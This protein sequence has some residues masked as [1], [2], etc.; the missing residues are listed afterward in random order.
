MDYYDL[1]ETT[2]AKFI[3][4]LN[5]FA[6]T[7]EL[8]GNL[9]EVHVANT[10]RMGELLYNGARVWLKKTDNLKRKL[11]Y[12]LLLSEY[13]GRKICLNA[14]LA[15]DFLARWLDMGY[16]DEFREYLHYRREY[17]FRESR[18]DFLLEN[19]NAQ[20]LLLEVKSVNYLLGDKAIFP[21]A[22]TERGRR[23]LEELAAW[24]REGLGKSAVVFVVM[25]HDAQ[26]FR[27]NE[28]TDPLFAQTLRAVKEEGVE[29][30]VYKSRIIGNKVY[31]DG[32][33]DY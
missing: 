17:C 4:R 21:D 20:K 25:G 12:D 30:L 8:N 31:F 23:H 7:V 11:A 19:E 22:P 32:K 15:N 27:T 6:A 10:G 1:G 13:A 33:I 29:V 16:L 24:Q 3:K 2:E 28:A 9:T 5:R 26:G 18:F 14:H